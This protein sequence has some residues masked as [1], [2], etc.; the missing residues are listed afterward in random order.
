MKINRIVKELCMIT[1]REPK[2][3]M[4]HMEIVLHYQ[5][6]SSVVEV[7]RFSHHLINKFKRKLLLKWLLRNKLKNKKRVI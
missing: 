4:N 1:T 7:R 6:I 2:D 5:R 3:M